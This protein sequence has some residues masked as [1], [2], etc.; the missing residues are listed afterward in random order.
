[1]TDVQIRVQTVLTVLCY[2]VIRVQTVQMQCDP[3]R[4]FECLTKVSWKIGLK[5]CICTKEY[6]SV[7]LDLCH[8]LVF[9]L[10]SASCIRVLE[11][12][13]TCGFHM[14]FVCKFRFMW[15]RFALI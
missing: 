9:G 2:P 10:F 14:F 6:I 4:I 11:K 1:M 12:I 7:F 3:S 13:L 8:E 15:A 5:S